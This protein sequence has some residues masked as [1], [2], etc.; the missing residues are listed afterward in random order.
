M[1]SDF[2]PRGHENAV[3]RQQLVRMTGMSDR[4]VRE[5]ISLETLS[6][7]GEIILNTGEG[8]FI[9]DGENDDHYLIDYI[10]QESSRFYTIGKKLRKLRKR[11]K[12]ITD[13]IAGQMSFIE[14]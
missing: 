9:Y 13:Q 8:Y 6:T 5:E 2:I 11:A 4:R 1:I 3:S 7:R 10:R 12:P 14:G